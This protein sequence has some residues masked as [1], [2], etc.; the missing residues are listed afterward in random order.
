MASVGFTPPRQ[1]EDWCDWALGIWLCLSP[2]VLLFERDGVATRNAVIVGGLIIL[3]EVIT[4]SVFRLWEEWINVVLGAWLIVSPWLLG[5][6]NAFAK[7]NF[8]V[9]G[10]LVLALAL[11]EVRSLRREPS[12]RM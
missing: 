1:W 12:R 4:L 6:T 9:V 10:V 2:W 3:A 8:V 5:I 7:G 11:Y